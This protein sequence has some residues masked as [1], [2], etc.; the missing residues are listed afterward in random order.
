MTNPAR[1]DFIWVLVVIGN[2][3]TYSK[4]PIILAII[5]GLCVRLPIMAPKPCIT[6]AKPVPDVA[7]IAEKPPVLL[8]P[9]GLNASPQ[10]A[11][12]FTCLNT[13]PFSCPDVLT[14]VILN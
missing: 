8:V 9:Q 12:L 5:I 1:S 4:V 2:P 6:N 11:V 10:K 13:K 14:A 3:T 7:V